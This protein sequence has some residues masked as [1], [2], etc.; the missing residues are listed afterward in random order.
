MHRVI[1]ETYRAG[2]W[3]LFAEEGHRDDSATNTY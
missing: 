1:A 2:G 3:G